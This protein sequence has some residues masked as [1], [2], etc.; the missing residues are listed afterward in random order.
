MLR[1]LLLF[2]LF[3]I[4][5]LSKEF[6][7]IEFKGES[8]SLNP[9]SDFTREKFLKLLSIE[10]PPIYKFYKDDPKFD[11]SNISEYKKLIEQYYKSKG[12]YRV[13]VSV[14]VLDDT[15][16]FNID[17]NEPILINSI[18]IDSDFNISKE[19][20]L[21]ERERFTTA[22]FSK[23]KSKIERKLLLSG[24][25]KYELDIKAYVDL[26]KYVVDIALLLR[27]GELN[28]FGDI[29]IKG[30]E[31]VDERF[32][33]ERLAIEKGDIFN[34]LEIEQSYQNLYNLKIF[35][36]ISIVPNL[37]SNSSTLLIE[38]ELKEAKRRTL[39]GSLGYSSDSGFGVS[40]SWVNRNLFG[41]LERVEV[42]F[43]LNQIEYAIVNRF[44][45]PKLYREFDFENLLEYKFNRYDGYDESLVSNLMTLSREFFGFRGYLGFHLEHS[46]IDSDNSTLY[47][48]D[49][50]Y[51]IN[52]LFARA[53][54]DRRDSKLNAT[55]G[56]YLD[57][58][59]EFANEMW[60]SELNFLKTFLEFRYIESSRDLTIAFKSK[61][62]TISDRVPIFKRFFSGGSFTN[63]GFGYREVG[64]VDSDGDPIG[65][66]T[67]LENSIEFRYPIYDSL[68]LA[69]F[70][71]STILELE[72][73]K[74]NSNFI[75]SYG[76]GFRYLTP[77]GPF[78][79]D[80][81]VPTNGGIE[82]MNFHF[83]IGQVY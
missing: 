27:K 38:I 3:T 44:E 6:T 51:F 40:G 18:K 16:R 36:T 71:D 73:Y 14:Q 55:D 19:F 1:F 10:Y 21:K 54:L 75:N 50:D 12:Y 41:E 5:I 15:L 82:D 4:S 46:S 76:F 61:L 74:F 11:S 53:L 72:P 22:K 63:R 26:E 7:N 83:S 52:S 8:I 56:Y 31:S 23:I 32:V 64:D 30:L 28:R 60:L 67:L 42:G 43:D 17:S 68:N 62:G 48:K 77:I 69:L 49:G 39:K 66:D 34:Q 57:L 58:K 37:E 24:F 20:N 13:E 29:T 2:T 79:L 35:D 33:R 80:F 45:V 59:V 70:F 25:A 65:G 47:I 81:G 9:I 78:R